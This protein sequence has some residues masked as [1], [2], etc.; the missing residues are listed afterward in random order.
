[1]ARDAEALL[2]EARQELR[3]VSASLAARIEELETERA[4]TLHLARTD[5]LTGLLN[6][7]AFTAAL[8]G[9]LEEAQRSGEPVALLV[10][11]LDRFKNLN[12]SL[13]HDAGD[14]LLI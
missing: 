11:D 8:V 7:G 12:D 9:R 13:G 10:I 3:Q 2:I 4:L 6:R 1:M 5:S 14:Q